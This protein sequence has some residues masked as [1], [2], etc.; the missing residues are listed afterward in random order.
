ML[1]S[2]NV[3]TPATAVAVVVPERVPPA[4]LVPSATVT[5][6]ANEASVLPG[7][8]CAATRTAGAIA[9]PAAVVPGWTV[10]VRRAGAIATRKSGAVSAFAPNGVHALARPV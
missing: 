7:A 4:R 5:V 3:A 8:S 10:T 6:P 2:A 9:A 1:K